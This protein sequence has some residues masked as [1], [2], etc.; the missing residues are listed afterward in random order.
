MAYNIS[1]RI[2]R[3]SPQTE[4]A[5]ESDTASVRSDETDLSDVSYGTTWS[6]PAGTAQDQPDARSPY[7]NLAKYAKYFEADKDGGSTKFTPSLRSERHRVAISS[8]FQHRRRRVH[9][10]SPAAFDDTTSDLGSRRHPSRCESAPHLDSD[11]VA[12]RPTVRPRQGSSIASPLIRRARPTSCIIE[13][14][15][16][17]RDLLN[18][19]DKSPSLTESPWRA[20][21]T[22][23]HRQPLFREHVG[24][25]THRENISMAEVRR[26][27]TAED[28][29]A[30]YGSHH[31][32]N[33]KTGS[34]LSET[35]PNHNEPL[36]HSTH[37]SEKTETTGGKSSS[38]MPTRDEPFKYGGL[39]SEKLETSSKNTDTKPVS[40]QDK[41]TRQ[42]KQ[43]SEYLETGATSGRPNAHGISSNVTGT[44]SESARNSKSH[45]DDIKAGKTSTSASSRPGHRVLPNIP[46][47]CGATETVSASTSRGERVRKETRTSD[48]PRARQL[49][50]AYKFVTTERN[51]ASSL[52]H[53][54]KDPGLAKSLSTN[55]SDSNKSES[56]T[57][58]LS[59]HNKPRSSSTNFG[60]TEPRKT[61]NSRLSS[62]NASSSRPANSASVKSSSDSVRAKPSTSTK[63]CDV[64]H[65]LKASGFS[66]KSSAQDSS[67][68]SKFQDSVKYSIHPDASRSKSA[69][70]SGKARGTEQVKSSQHKSDIHVSAGSKSDHSQASTEHVEKQSKG[71]TGGEKT[72]PSAGKSRS[73]KSTP[74]S[75]SRL[76]YKVNAAT[77]QPVLMNSNKT[78]RSTSAGQR[79]TSKTTMDVEADES[80]LYNEMPSTENV[81]SD[82]KRAST[83][84]SNV[85]S[86]PRAS[87]ASAS[88]D[89]SSQNKL[90]KDNCR[91]P[92]G[93]DDEDGSDR[94]SERR[95]SGTSVSQSPQTDINS[96][97]NEHHSASR[98]RHA[99]DNLLQQRQ[100]AT[101]NKTPA[102]ADAGI[103]NGDNEDAKNSKKQQQWQDFMAALQATRAKYSSTENR[104]PSSES[105]H[106]QPVYSD[107]ITPLWRIQRDDFAVP[108]SVAIA[109][110]G[111]SVIADIANCLLDFTD[112][113]GN[114]VHSVSGTKPFSVVVGANDVIYVGDRRSRT[115]RVFDIYGT[116]VA[117]WDAETTG[118]GWIAGIAMLR[119]GQL[120]IIDR[121]RCKVSSGL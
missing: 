48:V 6:A 115:V 80:P 16:D 22:D 28:E 67:I 99:E 118:F 74:G 31:S 23:R 83:Q 15:A 72:P 77:I 55:A 107:S 24:L 54:Q 57:T 9:A 33:V 11:G 106:P 59:D 94:P 71:S 10:P 20:A 120:A 37:H 21:S 104:T 52:D 2:G 95:D 44:R 103:A 13:E 66:T 79:S 101:D 112:V 110:D 58:G 8:S 105:S 51:H 91:R 41:S 90:K 7:P 40:S 39:H 53:R 96:Q 93:V 32:E 43:R 81:E 36:R 30:G 61:H 38:T 18:H 42:P 62:H 92:S 119:N 97:T 17:D 1:R 114:I 60:D 73:S 64:D 75:G 69:A 116:D 5:A 14:H 117:Q 29:Q 12:Y 35:A 82:N 98:T 25:P 65:I 56:S 87:T 76:R 85:V 121:E 46:T 50:K 100:A 26:S 27:K 111:S 108:T 109:S 84:Y 113:D 63:S 19:V 102:D 89:V 3:Q 88:S 34:V 78:K 47:D 49:S 45:S 70:T 86:E 4:R 68:P